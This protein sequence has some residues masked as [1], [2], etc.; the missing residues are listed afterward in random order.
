[1]VAAFAV[2]MLASHSGARRNDITVVK[3]ND[4]CRRFHIISSLFSFFSLQFMHPL[5]FLHIL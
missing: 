4:L 1:M 5:Y 3:V 2:A